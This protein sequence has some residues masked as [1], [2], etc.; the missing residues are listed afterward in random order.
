MVTAPKNLTLLGLIGMLQW[1]FGNLYEAV[2]ISPNWVV[3]S[4][5]A[6]DRLHGFFVRTTPTTYFV[7]FTL[8]APVAIWAAFA[9]H[10][11]PELKRASA[12][13]AAAAALNAFIVTTIVMK[14]FAEDYRSYSAIELHAL[15]VRW[16]VLNSVRMAL[17]AATIFFAFAAY[18]AL[19][20]AGVATR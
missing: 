13:A 7:P 8:L 20:R 4:P 6:L 17:T 15:C 16:N 3:D 18:R 14:L 19:D 9:L 11:S 12:F 2:V 10:R 1:L 5:A